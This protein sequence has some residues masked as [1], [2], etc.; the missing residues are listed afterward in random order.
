MYQAH[1][2]ISKTRIPDDV[3][4]ASKISFQPTAGSE[5]VSCEQ[6]ENGFEVVCQGPNEW[7]GTVTRIYP[8]GRKVETF[9]TGIQV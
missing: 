1:I 6:T 7:V 5:P 4:A 9:I 3:E 2:R 8:S